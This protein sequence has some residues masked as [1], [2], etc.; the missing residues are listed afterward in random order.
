MVGRVP[1][2][3]D[4]AI[5]QT[6]NKKAQVPLHP[7][8]RHPAASLAPDLKVGKRDRR[9]RVKQP[10]DGAVGQI[11]EQTILPQRRGGGI[12]GA[13]DESIAKQDID[14]PAEGQIDDNTEEK[15]IILR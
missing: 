15:L 3:A 8:P 2:D 7:I 13:I 9:N 4:S 5:V 6:P 11:D 14:W 1:F 10:G 12:D